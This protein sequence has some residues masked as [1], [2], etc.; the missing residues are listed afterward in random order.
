MFQLGSNGYIALQDTVAY[1]NAI[2]TPLNLKL[3][4]PLFDDIR[5]SSTGNIYYRQTSDA[6]DI[7]VRN[8]IFLSY[9]SYIYSNNS[10]GCSRNTQ[11][12]Q[13][14]SQ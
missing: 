6:A 10:T 9:F 12:I 2:P 1:A 4:A 8:N 3:I 5:P 14:N 7:T 13:R 11:N